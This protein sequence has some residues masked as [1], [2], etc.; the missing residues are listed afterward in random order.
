MRLER[1]T[2]TLLAGEGD[3]RGIYLKAVSH[4]DP[5]FSPPSMQSGFDLLPVWAT[6]GY[7][8]AVL[9][10]LRPDSCLPLSPP[11]EPAMTKALTVAL[12]QLYGWSAIQ[13]E[14]FCD[15][16]EDGGAASRDSAD[17]LLHRSLRDLTFDKAS[18]RCPSPR[19]FFDARSSRDSRL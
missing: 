18:E 10:W 16:A 14:R 9:A 3:C 1:T 13:F 6:K 15:L 19:G 17:S 4:S 11:L 7:C 5:L 2:L 8:V 12:S